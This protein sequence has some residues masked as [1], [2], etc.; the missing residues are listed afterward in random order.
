MLLVWT[1]NN[2]PHYK[3]K[4]MS[5]LWRFIMKRKELFNIL[6]CDSKL[7]MHGCKYLPCTD[8]LMCEECDSYQYWEQEAVIPNRIAK[9]ILNSHYGRAYYLDTDSLKVVHDVYHS[10]KTIAEDFKFLW[11]GWTKFPSLHNNMEW[12]MFKDIIDDALDNG[13]EVKI[14]NGT[15]YYRE[16]Q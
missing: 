10:G 1:G 14:L 9:S 8:D 4:E 7:V 13:F 3:T 5:L 2:C 6:F 15:I 12:S 11:Q 16:K